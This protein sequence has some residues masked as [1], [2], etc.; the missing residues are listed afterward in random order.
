MRAAD[1]RPAQLSEITDDGEFDASRNGP[2]EDDEA[3][4]NLS[5]LEASGDLSWL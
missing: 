3:L 5:C 4:S 1:R 2:E